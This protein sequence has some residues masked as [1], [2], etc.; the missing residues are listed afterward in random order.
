ML[1]AMLSLFIGFTIAFVAM[2]RVIRISLEKKLFDVPD[3]RKLH[4]T[5]IPSLGGISIFG[6]FIIAS[7]LCSYVEPNAIVQGQSQYLAA[8]FLVLFFTGVVD[9]VIEVSATKKLL[10]QII[11]ACIFYYKLK[12]NIT[13]MHGIFGVTDKFPDLVGIAFTF[14]TIIVITNAF[15]LIDGIDGLAASLGIVSTVFFGIY[16]I[17]TNQVTEAVWAFGMTGALLAFL[18][19]NHHPAKIFMGDAGSLTLGI[20]N[21]YL[22][23]R[24]IELADTQNITSNF[25]ITISNSPVIAMAVLSVPLLDTLRVFA[26][27]ILNGRSPFSPDRNHVHHLLADRGVS[28]NKITAYLASANIVI[29]FAA[30][31]AQPFVNNTALLVIMVTVCM[32]IIGWLYK[33][34]KAYQLLTEAGLNNNTKLANS[35]PKI[36][37]YIRNAMIQD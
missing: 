34:R 23:I 27:R 24:F 7:L 12:L 29:V 31:F 16:F 15:N 28:H 4:Q 14:F 32:L 20:L 26:I 13:S 6:G 33:K 21:A 37:K 17:G 22:A 3:F 5:P 36:I 11:A 9:D 25:N 1:Q 35:E 18:I 19:Y 10:A 30:Y 2:P 8:G